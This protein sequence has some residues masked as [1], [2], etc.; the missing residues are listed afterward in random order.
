[1]L[2][3]YISGLE[4][5]D[6]RSKVKGEK[7]GSKRPSLDGWDRA[8]ESA[9]DALTMFR[10]AEDERRGGDV[11]SANTT[12]E[13]ALLMLKDRYCFHS[14]VPAIVSYSVAVQEQFQLCTIQGSS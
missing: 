1:M 2:S 5:Y 4:A 9:Q 12:V 10:K 6:K 7:Q 14:R 8:L 13:E 11:H 3:A